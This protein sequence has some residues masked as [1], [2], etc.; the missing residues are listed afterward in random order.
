MAFVKLVL[1]EI[2]LMAGTVGI[3]V[4]LALTA[5][6][7]PGDLPTDRAFD[8]LGYKVILPPISFANLLARSGGLTLFFAVIA[9][10]LGGL[11]RVA[12]S[13][14]SSVGGPSREG[15]LQASSAQKSAFLRLE[16]RAFAENQEKSIGRR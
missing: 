1:G 2:M 8:L 13:S 16:T 10:V 3:A 12:G 6:P 9:G 11:Q 5:P 4:A 14:A 15:R 7:P